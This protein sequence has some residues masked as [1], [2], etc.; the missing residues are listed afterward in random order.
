[1]NFVNEENYDGSPLVQEPAKKTRCL[2][3]RGLMTWAA[4]RA[5]YGRALH[6]GLS[7]EQAKEATPRCRR[8]MAKYLEPIPVGSPCDPLA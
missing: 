1:M 8:C 4:Q 2:D 5:E 3:C 6:H 7:K